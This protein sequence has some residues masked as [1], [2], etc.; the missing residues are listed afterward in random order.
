ME[1]SEAPDSSAPPGAARLRL[2][3]SLAHVPPPREQ[4]PAQAG[5]PAAV[6]ASPVALQ[7]L[8]SARQP[9]T[10]PPPQIIA[11]ALG[12]P[13][14]RPDTAP[15]ASSSA[16]L[17]PLTA[18]LG[19]IALLASLAW[20]FERRRTLREQDSVLWADVLP[21][22]SSLRSGGS[23][24][25]DILPESPNPAETARAIFVTAIGETSSRREATL[26]DL[27]QLQ[28]KL[29]RRRKHGALVAA[30]LLLQQH[31]VDFRFTSPWV[32]LEL[33]ELY[34]ALNRHPEW[35]IAR[36]AFRARFG[37]NA[38]LWM[39]PSTA[40]A[41]MLDDSH[42]CSGLS[43]KWPYRA[44][45]MWLGLWMLGEDE[46]RH[47]AMGPPLLPL[48]VY[49]DMM[50]LDD[51]LDNVMLVRPQPAVAEDSAVI[52]ATAALATPAPVSVP[53]RARTPD[54]A[55]DAGCPDTVL[56]E[57]PLSPT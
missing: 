50:M 14:S 12:A 45:R 38:P 33:R 9:A 24:L 43:C 27:H 32:F 22:A 17:L 23:L 20:M 37:Q 56:D 41:Q 13:V 1:S 42:L 54:P 31:L 57:D 11:S 48:G 46:M 36:N 18:T 26:I 51:L 55:S 40:D 16:V 7:P 3:R 44:A 28:R 29:E 2:S 35:E 52:R 25:D 4:P 34:L 30:V 49:R 6:P 53:G 8:P 39:S 15:V 21:V 10:D 5:Q 47:R 19:G